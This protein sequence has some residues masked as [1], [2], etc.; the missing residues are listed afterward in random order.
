M[1]MRCVSILWLAITWSTSL[2]RSQ[3]SVGFEGKKKGGGGCAIFY[4]AK[5]DI[6][7]RHFCLTIPEQIFLL[8]WWYIC[9]FC[10]S[11]PKH[12]ER[13]RQGLFLHCM[14]ASKTKAA[15]VYRNK[16]R[17]AF[18]LITKK[19]DEAFTEISKCR[20]AFIL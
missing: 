1:L 8:P 17:Q 13:E 20:K 18:K 9:N 2:K 12:K 16:K 19:C 15:S 7:F 5:V 14:V 3:I 11:L 4:K 6:F 10:D